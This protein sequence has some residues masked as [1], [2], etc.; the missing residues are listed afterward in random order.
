MKY[1]YYIFSMILLLFS[2][3]LLSCTSSTPPSLNNKRIMI[4]GD[5]ITNGGQYASFI[6]YYLNKNY[7]Q[8]NFDIIS[9]GLSSETASG[10]S[11]ADHPFPRPCIHERLDRALDKVK[12]DIVLSCYGMNDGIYYPQ[13]KEN[14]AAYQKGITDLVRKV[15][16]SGAQAILLTPPPFDPLPKHDKLQKEGAKEYSF[17]APFYKYHKVLE[18]YSSWIMNLSD[19]DIIKV[20]LNTALTRHIAKK[21]KTIKDFSFSKDGIH[22]KSEGH[23]LMAQ[24]FLKVMGHLFATGDLDKDH[25]RIMQDPLFK[26][27]N[28]HRRLRSKGWLPYVGYT[29]GK[30]FSLDSIA[31]TE[32]RAAELQ[33]D[34][35]ALRQ[36][37]SLASTTPNIIYINVDDLGWADVN[38]QGKSTFYETPNIDKLSTQG[39]VF[40]NAY[41]PAANCAPSRACCQ[42]GQNTPRHGIYTV[43]DSS[44]GNV[45]DR[46]LIPIKN[47]LQIAETNT[48]IAHSLK[49]AGYTTC[50]IGKWHISEDSTINGYD[51]NIAG[52]HSGSPKGGYFSPFKNPNIKD[53]PKGEHLT[54]RLTTEAINFVTQNKNKAFY[55]YLTYYSVHTPLQAKK[56]LVKKYNNKKSTEAHAHSTYAAMIE[57]MDTNIGR[58]MSTLDKEGLTDNTLVL[59]TSDNG[60]IWKISR[61]WPLRAGK[62]SYYEG[63]I[64]EP[65]IVRWPGKVKAG[66]HCDVPVSG[67]DFLPTFIEVA[68]TKTPNKILDGNSLVPLLTHTGTLKE[69]PL[70]WHFPIYLQAYS[71]DNTDSRDNKFRTRPGSV[72]R[73]G[74]WKLHQYFENNDLELYNLKT[75]IGEKNNLSKKHPEKT[76]ELLA[77]LNNWRKETKAPVP[78]KLNPQYKK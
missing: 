64:R 2:F 50:S 24:E 13:S 56:E 47:T 52:N 58:L 32:K 63:G 70:Y 71:L 62:G 65:L 15:K 22:P 4:L 28:Q 20:D 46:K 34:I 53:G 9:I 43:G 3:F 54:D 49:Q 31:D 51:I 35:D 68:Q 75:D 39:M 76:K 60:G 16:A 38:Y 25:A 30:T 29:R 37:P 6:E 27:V 10:L 36:Q 19:P 26:I 23:L 59:F 33:K 69:R 55:L 72:I 1:R 8:Q 42:T 44:R 12:P 78:T 7:P 48:T 41:A 5:S 40:S 45:T 74:D 66:S 57:T 11:E 17:K 77:L 73:L 18:D 67:L 61:Q 21:R 14:F